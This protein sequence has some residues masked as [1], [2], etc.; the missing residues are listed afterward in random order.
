MKKITLLIILSALC[1]NTQASP[2]KDPERKLLERELLN[3]E[4]DKK[5]LEKHNKKYKKIKKNNFIEINKED[6]KT[7]DK[8]K[9][10]AD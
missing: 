4:T 7:K 5:L 6:G 9:V 8:K 10:Y 1:V 2:Q 3:S